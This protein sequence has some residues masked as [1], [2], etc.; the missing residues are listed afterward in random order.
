MFFLKGHG[1]P[2]EYL[3]ELSKRCRA[4]FHSSPASRTQVGNVDGRGY[5]PA[6]SPSDA[7]R[8]FKESFNLMYPQP[9]RAW[10]PDLEL[11]SLLEDAFSR[12]NDLSVTLLR[13]FAGG[14]ERSE[15]DFLSRIG[16]DASVLRI[17][18][19]PPTSVPLAANWRCEPHT[20]YG[21]VSILLVD[22]AP[23]GLQLRTSVD[24]W[25]DVPVPPQQ[26]LVNLGDTLENW[27]GGRL[28]APEHRVVNP[29]EVDIER[30]SRQAIVFFYNPDTI[31][32][33]VV[34][35]LCG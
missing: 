33:K 9:V 5:M 16:A 8:E 32:T 3:A 6:S 25:E 28:V 11:C 18:H 22:D 10:P 21:T 2:T 12:F 13:L 31:R 17:I 34:N 26:L 20:D 35:Y 29:S 30:S 7:S 19:Y 14:L 27:T 23:G 4:F 1:I 15:D 24:V